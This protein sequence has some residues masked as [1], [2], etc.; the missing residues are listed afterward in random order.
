MAE[1]RIT[2]QQMK[3]D[4]IA[5]TLTAW[6]QWIEEHWQFAAL[7]VGGAIAAVLAAYGVTTWMQSSSAAR[8]SELARASSLLGAEV[9]AQGAKPADPLAP[10]FATAAARDEA[11]LVAIDAYVRDYGEDGRAL[12]Y[13]G[14]ALT[15]LGRNSEAEATL[16]RAIEA[17]LPVDVGIARH[18]QASCALARGD[19]ATAVQRFSALVDAPPPGYP[20]DLLLAELAR[21][22]ELAGHP[23]EAAR[24]R[25]RIAAE[26]PNSPVA[27]ALRSRT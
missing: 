13:R 4:E 17:A 2:R 15:R 14:V 20:V 19:F 23:E 21:S 1:R 8:A 3:H 26:F 18:A 7:V 5:D 27:D 12:T 11:A 9:V 22:Q 25:E 6:S 24:T 16:T 10:T